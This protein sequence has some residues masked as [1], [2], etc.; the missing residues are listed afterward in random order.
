MVDKVHG[1]IGVVAESYFLVHEYFVSE[2][3]EDF[4]LLVL[5]RV[6]LGGVPGAA[7]S[8]VFAWAPEAR[9]Q[10]CSKGGDGEGKDGEENGWMHFWNRIGVGAIASM[11]AGCLMGVKM[12]AVLR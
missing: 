2:G 1:G 11:Q 7:Q 10:G 8:V 4:R 6:G 9:L 3:V 12:R 5:R